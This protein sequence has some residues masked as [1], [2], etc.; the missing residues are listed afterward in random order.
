MG[1]DF[2]LDRK[3]RIKE[4]IGTEALVG[5]VKSRARAEGILQMARREG[6]NKPPAEIQITLAVVTPQGTREQRQVSV[7]SLLDESAPLEQMAPICGGCPAAVNGKP[8]GCYGSINYPI[9]ARTEQWLMSLL[10]GDVQ[11][12]IGTV[13]QQAIKDFHY[14]GEPIM[15]LRSQRT[16]FED[17]RGATRTWKSGKGFFAKVSNGFSVTSSQLLQMMFCVGPLQPSHCGM[18]AAFLG[19][20]PHDAP[21]QALTNK[22]VFIAAAKDMPQRILPPTDAPGATNFMHLFQAMIGAVELEVPV[23]VDY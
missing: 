23:L 1:V 16:F 3:C 18:V 13:L 12:P 19:L 15:K 5:L 22:A 11:S 9:A 14:D 2:V 21:P 20:I 6:N 7:Q 4:A 17:P 8:F 10:P